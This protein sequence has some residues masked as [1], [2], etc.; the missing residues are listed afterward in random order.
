[1][2]HTGSIR[3][4]NAVIIPVIGQLAIKASLSQ[5]VQC[6][7]R[8]DRVC[9]VADQQAEVMHFASFTR[10]N[11]QADL[12]SQFVSHKMMMHSTGGH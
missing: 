4:D 3:R 9:T 8:I 6:K 12:S 2:R 7:I 1:M 5:S 10:L 11:Q